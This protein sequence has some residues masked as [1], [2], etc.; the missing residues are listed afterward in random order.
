MSNTQ[1]FLTQKYYG[2]PLVFDELVGILSLKLVDEFDEVAVT[3]LAKV[4]GAQVC[5]LI[6]NLYVVEAEL[7]LFHQFLHEKKLSAMCFA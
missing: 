1:V 7:A 3:V 6:L 4:L 5:Q 2:L